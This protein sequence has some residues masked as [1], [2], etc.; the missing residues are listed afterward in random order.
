MKKNGNQKLQQ[1]IGNEEDSLMSYPG[2][3]RNG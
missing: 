2:H 3:S 1:P